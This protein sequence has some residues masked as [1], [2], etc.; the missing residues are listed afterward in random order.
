ME[1]NSPENIKSYEVLSSDVYSPDLWYETSHLTLKTKRKLLVAAK[2]FSFG[3]YWIDVLHSFQR[4]KI[5]MKWNDI[6]DMLDNQSH[7]VVIYRRGYESWK[8]NND[9]FN[10]QKWALE[11]GFSTWGSPTYYLWIYIK[12]RY[13]ELLIK[14][15]KLK[16]RK[17]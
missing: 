2:G 14:N 3:N 13:A 10:H 7:F 8:E 16:E 12:D 9:T 17:V 1:T 15:F 4:K 11:L 5:D 6:L